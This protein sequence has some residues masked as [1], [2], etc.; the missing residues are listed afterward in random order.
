[1]H[2]KTQNYSQQSHFTLSRPHS[3]IS[4][5]KNKTKN[6]P[7]KRSPLQCIFLSN[8]QTRSRK[9]K[10]RNQGSNLKKLNGFCREKKRERI[11]EDREKGSCLWPPPPLH[12]R[13][14]PTV[15]ERALGNPNSAASTTDGM[16][17][18]SLPPQKP[19]SFSLQLALPCEC[20]CHL[21]CTLKS[22]FSLKKIVSFLW[23]I[24][25]APDMGHGFLI[26][27]CHF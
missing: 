11:V 26:C 18:L 22:H 2:I 1:M 13:P 27:F 6:Y 20:L 17:S 21:I 24:I 25:L 23:S 15:K 8:E 7:K 4:H 3:I 16:Y 19:H 14:N 12:N 9:K 10:T 5:T